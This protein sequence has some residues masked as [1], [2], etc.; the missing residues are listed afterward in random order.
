MGALV[1]RGWY[2][3]GVD[4]LLRLGNNTDLKW[5]VEG[6]GRNRW[7]LLFAPYGLLTSRVGSYKGWLVTL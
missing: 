4:M 5:L 3:Q 1:S 6:K 2:R 7:S